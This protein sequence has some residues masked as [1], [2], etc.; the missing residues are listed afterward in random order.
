MPSGC[1]V[2]WLHSFFP[3]Y[4]RNVSS[5]V[6][7]L[8]ANSRTHNPE[9]KGGMFFRNVGNKL[10]HP[11]GVTTRKTC[12]LSTGLQLTISFSAASFPVGKAAGFSHDLSCIFRYSLSRSRLLHKRSDVWL[13][14]APHALSESEGIW[15]DAAE[16]HCFLCM[17]ARAHVRFKRRRMAENTPQ[18]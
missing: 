12:F 10:T 6:L 1:C 15:N 13:R 18:A 7:R 4:R 5:K 2:V 3:T 17:R 16:K 9:K 14:Y 8:K 11:H